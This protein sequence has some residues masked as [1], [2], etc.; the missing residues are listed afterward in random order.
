MALSI[1][2]AVVAEIIRQATAELPNESCG[3][4]L[5][6]EEVVTENYKMTNVDASPEHFSFDPKE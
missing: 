5:G 6:K 2:G 1:E 4:L 3:Y